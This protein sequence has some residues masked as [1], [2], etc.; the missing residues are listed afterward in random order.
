MSNSLIDS[1]IN[2]TKCSGN[3][4]IKKYI[5]KEL[6]KTL[7]ELITNDYNYENFRYKD[8]VIKS[9]IY[10]IIYKE[11]KMN[12]ILENEYKEMISDD[13]FNEG[14]KIRFIIEVFDRDG[15]LERYKNNNRYP[16]FVLSRETNNNKIKGFAIYSANEIFTI[17]RNI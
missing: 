4:I 2:Y 7:N 13:S 9:K 6:S 11:L 14:T 12:Q 3:I 17:E 1:V 5:N 16:L 8:K 10:N 15:Y